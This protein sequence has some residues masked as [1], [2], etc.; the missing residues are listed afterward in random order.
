[1]HTTLNSFLDSLLIYDYLLFAGSFIFFIFF[2]VLGLVYRHKIYLAM[3]LVTLAFCILILGPIFGY[4][5][6]HNYFY[7]N[8]ISLTSQKKLQFTQAVV[9]KGELKNLS[10]LHFNRCLISASAY[11]VSG[12]KYKDFLLKF[13]PFQKS[14]IVEYDIPQDHMIDFKIIIEPF[15][16]SGDYNISVEASC[17]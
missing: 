9:V 6:I 5:H 16:Y 8:E 15:V 13:N 3:F 1:M 10:K 14:S 7:Y 11:K 4:I 17:Q 2:V 12:N